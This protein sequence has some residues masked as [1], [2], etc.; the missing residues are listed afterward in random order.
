MKPILKDAGGKSDE[1]IHI[2][3]MIPQY[4]RFVE[5]FVGGGSLYFHL[6]PAQALINDLNSRLVNFYVELRDQYD[7]CMKQLTTLHNLYAQNQNQYTKQIAQGL[8]RPINQNDALYYDLRNQFNGQP[9]DYLP[10]VLYY[11]IN[12]TAYGG[13]TRYN[14]KGRFNIPFGRYASFKIDHITTQHRDLLHNTQI[15][16]TDYS[17]VFECVEPSDFVFLD[18]PY[19]CKFYEYGNQARKDTDN[20]AFQRRLASDFKNL[21]CPSLMVVAQTPLIKDL[22]AGYIANK[23]LKKYAVNI[24]NRFNQDV[25]HLIIKNY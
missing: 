11:F 22:Y 7:L 12:R 10:A 15:H 6:S 20:E 1:L 4:T 9:S 23:Y 8:E 2:L 3:P 24:K 18:P 21:H 16:N 13:L 5:P 19:D 14:Q 17:S 25:E